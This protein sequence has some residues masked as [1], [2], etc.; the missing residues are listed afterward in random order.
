MTYVELN[1]K[2]ILS[3]SRKLL[4][5][6]FREGNFTDP[7]LI[8]TVTWLFRTESLE[9]KGLQNLFFPMVARR[10][11][12]TS[13][14]RQRFLVWWQADL[15]WTERMPETSMIDSWTGIFVLTPSHFTLRYL[16]LHYYALHFYNFWDGFYGFRYKVDLE[17]NFETSVTSIQLSHRV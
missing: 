10:L 11:V 16:E 8:H 1:L 9:N 2:V 7:S 5:S 14:V 13:R 15:S 4:S 6:T 12:L 17:K 3:N